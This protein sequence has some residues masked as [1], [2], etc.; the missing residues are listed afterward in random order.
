MFYPFL[1]FV[2]GDPFLNVC[3]ALYSFFLFFLLLLDLK[4]DPFCL[5][6]FGSWLRLTEWKGPNPFLPSQKERT[7][8]ELSLRQGTGEFLRCAIQSMNIFAVGFADPLPRDCVTRFIDLGAATLW[9]DPSATQ[10]VRIRRRCVVYPE[11]APWPF[12]EVYLEQLRVE[13]RLPEESPS[14]SSSHV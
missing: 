11:H 3:C 5:M 7:S 4:R 10:R 12:K 1:P 6:S 13:K 8:D 14:D 9:H 2:L